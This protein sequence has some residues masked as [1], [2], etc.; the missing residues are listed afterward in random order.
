MSAGEEKER[1]RLV[2]KR[3]GSDWYVSSWKTGGRGG[4]GDRLGAGG[5]G[6]ETGRER[7]RKT[8]EEGT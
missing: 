8:G 2:S 5:A 3:C 7:E 1:S 4:E 6:R